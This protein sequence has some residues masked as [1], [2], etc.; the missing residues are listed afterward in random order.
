MKSRFALVLFTLCLFATVSGF[1]QNYSFKKKFGTQKNA[2]YVY[3]GYNRAIY[4]ASD[5]RFYSADYD[6]TVR[7]VRAQDRPVRT[8]S[9]YVDPTTITVPQFN[10]RLGWYYKFRWDISIGYDHMKYVMRD[11]QSLYINGNAGINSTSQL[12]GTYS[13]LDGLIPIRHEDLHYENTNGLNYVSIQLNNTSPIFKTN[14]RKFAVQRRV[15]MGVGP[16]IT[17]TD[18]AWDGREY[19]SAQRQKFA[20]YG[21]S[22]HTGLRFDFFNRFFLQ[23][24]WSG[25]F[26]HLPKNATIMELD[27]FAQQKFLYGQWELLGGVLF[28]LRSKNGCDTCPDWH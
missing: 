11:N 28:Y 27:H 2:M 8:F 4:T 13:N 25:G 9:T 17:Q 14:D 23:S 18:F 5:I 24:N 26:I 10:I 19:H 20:G 6:F 1:G 16:V 7:D 22:L 3:W 12:N 15:G 21:I